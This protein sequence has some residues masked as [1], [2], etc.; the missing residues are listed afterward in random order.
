MEVFTHMVMNQ[1]DTGISRSPGSRQEAQLS[2]PRCRQLIVTIN[3]YFIKS[4][5]S[6]ILLLLKL[7][8]IYYYE[9]A[10]RVFNWSLSWT[11]SATIGT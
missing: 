3:G 9:K 4:R 6:I 10:Y 8:S 2:I 11:V 7:A 5:Q 1:G